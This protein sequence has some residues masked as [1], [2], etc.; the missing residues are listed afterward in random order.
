MSQN[1]AV[2]LRPLQKHMFS[3]PGWPVVLFIHLYIRRLVLLLLL[4]LLVY[5]GAH[6][7]PN[8]QP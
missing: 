3:L 2:L 7:V 5:N 1:E 4:S 8:P 6:V